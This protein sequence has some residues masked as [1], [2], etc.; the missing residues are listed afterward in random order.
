MTLGLRGFIN[1][2]FSGLGFVPIVELNLGFR[3]F[4]DRS[5]ERRN[6]SAGDFRR[7][8]WYFGCFFKLLFETRLQ[9][10]RGLFFLGQIEFS[11]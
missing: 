10:G 7:V 2:R 3:V 5:T 4:L 1:G 8:N 11:L 6:G 9:K